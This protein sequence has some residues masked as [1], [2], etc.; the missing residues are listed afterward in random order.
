MRKFRDNHS[1]RDNARCF[2]S[3]SASQNAIEKAGKKAMVILY[4][5][6]VEDTHGFITISPFL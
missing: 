3:H 2:T 6:K 5:G 4:N 1:F